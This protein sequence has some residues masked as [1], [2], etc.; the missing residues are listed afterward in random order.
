VPKDVFIPRFGKSAKNRLGRRSDGL[1]FLDELG[2]N[3]A[4]F[5]HQQRGDAVHLRA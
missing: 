4:L 1:R 3:G 2:L 5:I